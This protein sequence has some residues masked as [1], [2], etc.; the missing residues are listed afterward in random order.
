MDVMDAVATEE[1]EDAASAS[2]FDEH[3]S[4]EQCASDEDES[5]NRTEADSRLTSLL[6]SKVSK[7]DS[8]RVKAIMERPDRSCNTCNISLSRNCKHLDACEES[9]THRTRCFYNRAEKEV[10]NTSSAGVGLPI[11]AYSSAYQ[12]GHKLFKYFMSFHDVEM[13]NSVFDNVFKC[14]QCWETAD[15]TRAESVFLELSGKGRVV[16]SEYVKK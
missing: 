8:P 7:S 1:R 15:K 16:T 10:T 3:K 13:S 14:S 6:K 12:K 9:P 11:V 5:C 4:D 2:C